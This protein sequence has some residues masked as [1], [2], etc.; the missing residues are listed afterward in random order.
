ML[1]RQPTVACSL[2]VL[3]LIYCLSNIGGW[4]APELV[5]ELI[6]ERGLGE[7][8]AGAVAALEMLGLAVA[9]LGL[10]LAA[11]RLPVRRLALFGSALLVLTQLLSWRAESLAGLLTLRFF[12]GV[13]Q[14]VLM[15][16]ANAALAA[17]SAPHRRLA[18]ANLVNVLFGSAL[19]FSLAPLRSAWPALGLFLVL[20]L[21]CLVLAPASFALPA[22]LQVQSAPV[23]RRLGLPNMTC[24][25]LVAAIFV[26]GCTSGAAFT[27]AH[28]MGEGAGLGES[29][30]NLALSLSVLG[31]FP[32]SA[33]CGLINTRLRSFWPL[34][35]ALLLHSLA[36]LM[37]SH[38]SGAWSF[39]F[40][41]AGN[42][43]AAYFL[44]PYLQGL[45]ARYD[46]YGGCCAA[47]GGAFFLS[48]AGGA[49][50]GGALVQW[51]GV[52]ALGWAVVGSNLLVGVLLLLS[53]GARRS[54]AVELAAPRYD[55][56]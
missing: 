13:G 8:G 37:A 19:L 32:G 20:T 7:A 49:Y 25:G 10:S 18:Q 33:L 41:L 22:R 14:G 34:T 1:A 55:F 24:Y 50:L 23:R 29:T 21:V 26:F 40:G 45:S 6:G 56:V 4:V 44:L 42:L 9:A 38:A 17:G 52:N 47:I 2:V 11:D 5:F 30:I 54:V 16:L 46:P 39:G 48:M 53:L 12:C 31:A 27:F 51:H 43:G 15:A 3:T 35:C 36:N 28:L